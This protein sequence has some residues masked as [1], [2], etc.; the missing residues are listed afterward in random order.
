MSSRK[1]RVAAILAALVAGAGLAGAL[2]AAAQQADTLRSGDRRCL[3]RR[4]EDCLDQPVP[5]DEPHHAVCSTCH[6][7]W[8][9]GV[10]L[11]KT[12]SCTD[13]GCHSG[14]SP[15]SVF[16]QT[17]RPEALTDCLHCHKAHEFRV[18]K[19]GADCLAC[20]KGGGSFVDWM[21]ATPA[22]SLNA[23]A[24]FR[25]SD[26]NAVE[27]SRCHG[28]GQQHGTLVVTSLED[29]RA[30]H[31]S[32]PLA[33]NCTRCHE[34]ESLKGVPLK[35]TRSLD[36]RIGSLD[37]PLRVLTFDHV[38]HVE[39]GCAKCHTSGSDL[40]AA[41]GA[42]CSSCHF[43]H[44][45]PDAD[46][47]QC[48]QPPARGAHTIQAHMGCS[49]TGCHVSPPQGIRDAP[50]TRALCLACHTTQKDHKPGQVCVDCHLLPPTGGA[51][52]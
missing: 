5:V 50:R 29:C 43:Q 14:A 6:N 17:V 30:C 9:Q 45:L 4:P 16:H 48:H 25:H 41:V 34:P 8:E 28:I 12:R 22:R 1:L 21:S 47:S 15:L 7:R 49:G 20:H 11:N 2:P 40:R 31:H 42:D 18:P 52:S 19:N 39:V 23:P 10:P 32:P 3:T 33:D 44:H 24:E 26:H 37:R 38:Y 46:C 36:I 27:C 35:V 51:G 13:A